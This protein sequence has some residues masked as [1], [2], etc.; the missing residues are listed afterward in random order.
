METQRGSNCVDVHQSQRDA[1]MSAAK[2]AG[3]MVVGSLFGLFHG[4]AAGAGAG[5]GRK[6]AAIGTAAG[7]VFLAGYAARAIRRGKRSIQPET[8]F[9][10]C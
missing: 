8:G 2:G 10:G 7:T 9:R 1:I 5:N 6:G 3:G 4:A